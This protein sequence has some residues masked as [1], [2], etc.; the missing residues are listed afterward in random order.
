MG[1]TNTSNTDSGIS[2]TNELNASRTL[3]FSGIL[4]GSCQESI[5]TLNQNSCVPEI[6]PGEANTNVF[7]SEADN[8]CDETTVASGIILQSYDTP[9]EVDLPPS[10][11]SQSVNNKFIRRINAKRNNQPRL[12]V[13]KRKLNPDS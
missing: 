7:I 8:Q 1:F 13:R 12:L 9:S 4:Q 11:Q 10:T 2:S 5:V 6:I 3:S